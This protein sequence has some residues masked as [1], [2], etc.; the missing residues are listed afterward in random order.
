MLNGLYGTH[1]D[2]FHF[3]LEG[4][5]SDLVLLVKVEPQLFALLTQTTS[6]PQSEM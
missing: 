3:D 5:H 1:Y 4:L 2:G 6:G